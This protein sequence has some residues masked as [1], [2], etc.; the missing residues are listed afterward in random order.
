MRDGVRALAH[1]FG[2]SKRAE[3]DLHEACLGVLRLMSL[4]TG[5]VSRDALA[6]CFAKIAGELEHSEFF[7]EALAE[8]HERRR[9]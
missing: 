5:H 6:L 9:R 4:F 2:E 1:A 8:Y 3:G 7:C